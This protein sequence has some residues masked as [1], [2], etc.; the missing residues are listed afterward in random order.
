MKHC[1]INGNIV[2]EDKIVQENLWIEEDRI[3]ALTNEIDK[4]A[5]LIDA[6]GMYVC[7]GFI[8]VHTHGKDGL[9]T[10]NVTQDNLEIL[11]MAHARTGVTSVLPTT[12]TA[13]IEDTRHTIEV[14]YEN[15]DRV[16]GAKIIGVHMEGPFFNKEHK[17]A[18]PE[19]YILKPSIEDFNKMVGEH[20][21]FIKILSLAPEI[22]GAKALTSYLVDQGITVSIGH[23]G[24]TYSQ[25]KEVMDL[26]ANHITH[27]FN[28]MTPLH[29]RNPGVVGLA[30]DEK[31]AYAELILDG[32]H[33]VDVSA[34]ILFN[35][36]GED[37]L[38]LVTDSMEAS[39]KEPGTYQL[40]GQKVYV[41]EGTAR[42]EDGTLAGSILC[43]NEAV[44]NA[45]DFFNIPLYTAVKCASLN[46][47]RSIKMDGEIGS[48]A[49]NKK[50]DIIFMND[51]Y[52]VIHSFIDG[53]QL[54]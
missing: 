43:M 31:E 34:R 17:G 50:A 51:Q 39:M 14:L 22:E 40:G 32:H 47:A 27:T 2:L 21:G 20:S 35:A 16:K 24:A 52:E 19:Q 8:D 5:A 30:M 53:K 25:A 7:P 29:H 6:K 45:V 41:K 38:V 15:K 13:S 4:E 54:F 46:P 28:A 9:D 26:G 44:K 3:V 23:T 37:H 18:Q 42:L 33:V 1:I 48:I 12:M 10:M 49:V 36:K 11:T